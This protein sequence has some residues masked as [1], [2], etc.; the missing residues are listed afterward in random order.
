M[1]GYPYVE[2]MEANKFVSIIRNSKNSKEERYAN[3]DAYDPPAHDKFYT[4]LVL[5][6]YDSSRYGAVIVDGAPLIRIYDMYTNPQDI[7]IK[8]RGYNMLGY[9]FE[10]TILTVPKEQIIRALQQPIGE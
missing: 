8:I 6:K 1:S 10:S 7:C 3:I 9:G 4:I 5:P 2:N